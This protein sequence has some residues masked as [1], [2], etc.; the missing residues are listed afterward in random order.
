[1][2]SELEQFNRRPEPFAEYTAEHLW[3]DP[4]ISGRM[5]ALHLDG[6]V[7]MASRTSGF[8]ARSVRWLSEYGGL[9]EGSRVLDLGC[10]P[11]LYSN[12]LA[13]TGAEVVGVDF[14]ERS[15]AYAR[16]TASDA[17]TAPTFVRGDYLKI[18]FPGTFDLAV[19]AMYD[20]CALSPEQRHTL[21]TRV[22]DVLRPGGRFIFDVFGLQALSERT[23]EIAYAPG[24][25]D[26]FWSAQEYH[27]FLRTFI[28]ETDRIVLD[29]Y[30][31]VE[32]DRTTTVYNWLQYYDVATLTAEVERAGLQVRDVFGDLAGAEL[33][34]AESE[35]CLVAG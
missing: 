35:I 7:D 19:L 15:I 3:T 1:M 30:L 5:L 31:I 2:F 24:L 10:G 16:D 14:S 17:P 29:K 25:M 8:I 11:G 22:R 4:H 23:E 9:G 26:G 12:P 28:Y 20:F 34:A 6:S 21:L 18:D 13:R 32:P 33:P 27:G